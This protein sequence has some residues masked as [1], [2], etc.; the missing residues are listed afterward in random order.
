MII[1][2]Y[3]AKSSPVGVFVCRQKVDF[4]LNSFAGVKNQDGQEI[5]DSSPERLSVSA[6]LAPAS[7]CSR[8]GWITVCVE[9]GDN[10]SILPELSVTVSRGRALPPMQL[11]VVVAE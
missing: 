3:C 2:D 8:L 4:F 5:R 9:R 7:W 6:E 1:V 11:A 10:V